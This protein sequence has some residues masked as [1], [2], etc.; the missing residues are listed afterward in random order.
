MYP[1][2]CFV[3]FSLSYTLDLLFL[4][5][6]KPGMSS[7][8]ETALDKCVE[9]CPTNN[10]AHCD[11]VWCMLQQSSRSMNCF[12]AGKQPDVS[13]K[14]L[15]NFML[16]N[17]TT[18]SIWQHWCHFWL[19]VSFF[20]LL[21]LVFFDYLFN[22]TMLHLTTTPSFLTR[23]VCF[24]V[25]CIFSSNYECNDTI[26]QVAMVGSCTLSFKVLLDCLFYFCGRGFRV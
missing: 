4:Q 12:E 3:Y 10:T 14:G 19:D 7:T 2:A 6:F 9:Y 25:L 16:P 5:Y 13:P 17:L 22:L 18:C 24:S 23:G 21:F 20:Q 11:D 15:S 8:V 26:L 1:F